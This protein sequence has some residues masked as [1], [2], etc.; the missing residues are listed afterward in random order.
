MDL[1]FLDLNLGRVNGLDLIKP[2]KEVSPKTKILIVSGYDN[3]KFVKRAFLNGADGY[4]LKGSK[5]VELVEA[6]ETVMMNNTFMGKGVQVS[7]L[8]NQTNERSG[9]D[10]G[11]QYLD[12]YSVRQRL[13]KREHEILQLITQ[14][15]SNKQIGEKLFISDQTVSVHRKNIMRKLGVTNTV[16]LVKAAQSLSISE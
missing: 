13:T 2:I 11:H 1:V 15:Y 5:R 9:K 8:L 16:S 3:Q 4:L 6:I 14:A 7:A 12:A 10:P